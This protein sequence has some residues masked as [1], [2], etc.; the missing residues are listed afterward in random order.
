MIASNKNRFDLFGNIV[1]EYPENVYKNKTTFADK[2]KHTQKSQTEC[3][4]I[5]GGITNNYPVNVY[6]APKKTTH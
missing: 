2:I 3:L 1:N 6:K 4:K 5:M